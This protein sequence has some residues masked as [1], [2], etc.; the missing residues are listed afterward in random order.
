MKRN[1]KAE[2]GGKKLTLSLSF[3]TSLDLLDEVGSPSQML[4][5]IISESQARSQGKAVALGFKLTERTATK[6]LVIANASTEALDFEEMGELCFTQ[7]FLEV[8][9]I[10]VDY[11]TEMISGGTSDGGEL[12][13]FVKEEG[14]ETVDGKN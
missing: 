6:L 2:I 13:K 8:Y 3:G 14:V 10:V 1:F 9:G 7:G 4:Q 11:L 5:D 12:A